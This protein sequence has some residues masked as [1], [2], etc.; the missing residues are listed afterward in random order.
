MILSRRMKKSETAKIPK[1]R[2][3]FN[4]REYH[5]CSKT[6]VK[7]IEGA[8]YVKV[9]KIGSKVNDIWYYDDDCYL[10][11]REDVLELVDETNTR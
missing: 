5:K 1:W 7:Y 4:K 6:F 11:V 9:L 8:K 10:W 2:N 3:K